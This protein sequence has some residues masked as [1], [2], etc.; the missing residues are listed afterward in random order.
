[1]CSRWSL[2]FFAHEDIHRHILHFKEYLSGGFLVS[3]GI[4]SIMSSF[5]DMFAGFGEWWDHFWKGNGDNQGWRGETTRLLPA[6]ATDLPGSAF[7]AKEVTK[8]AL[9]LR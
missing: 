3:R 6:H 1:M 9:R 7:P 8:V 2:E 5:G 4:I